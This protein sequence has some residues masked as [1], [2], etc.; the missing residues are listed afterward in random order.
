MSNYK[1]LLRLEGLIKSEGTSADYSSSHFLLAKNHFSYFSKKIKNRYFECYDYYKKSKELD[2]MQH[3]FVDIKEFKDRFKKEYFNDRDDYK[4]YLT[5]LF[6]DWECEL[7][8]NLGFEKEKNHLIDTKE[9]MNAFNERK[10]N[11]SDLDEIHNDV[12]LLIYLDNCYKEDLEIFNLVEGK[13]D[14]IYKNLEENEVL[15]YSYGQI[16]SKNTSTEELLGFINKKKFEGKIDYELELSKSQEY[17]KIIFFKDDSVALQNRNG[18]WTSPSFKSNVYSDVAKK[19]SEEYV[20]YVFRKKP[21]YKNI[22]IDKLRSDSYK[23]QSFELASKNL[24]QFEN[25]LKS[26]D[27]NYFEKIKSKDMSV[28]KVDDYINKIVY[29][30]KV[31]KFA[32]SIISKKYNHLYNEESLSFFKELYDLNISK[33]ILSKNIGAKLAGFKS[34]EDFNMALQRFYNSLNDFDK[35]SFLL[36]SKNLNASVVVDENDLLILKIEDFKASSKLGSAS[37]CI[38]RSNYYFQD[39]TTDG[40]S[41]FFI[42]DFTKDS[43]DENSMIGITLNKEGVKTAMHNKSDGLIVDF[44]TIEKWESVINKNLNNKT[45]NKKKLKM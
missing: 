42:Y 21:K 17:Q 11:I 9:V 31:K 8:K 27:V 45:E 26:Q 18:S 10:S 37:W 39:Y 1:I 12:D 33:S 29:E 14:L 13:L 44:K 23:M 25:T 16:F 35:D 6:E 3:G 41:Q 19:I 36:K 28:E 7:F 30:S 24:M 2:D 22:F 20:D 38:S 34:P 43:K 40:N 15:E 5:I 32:M 4:N